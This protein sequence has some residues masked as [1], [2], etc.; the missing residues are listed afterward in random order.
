MRSLRLL[1]LLLLFA[2]V[3]CVAD[4]EELD[5]DAET[6]DGQP[7]PQAAFC[8]LLAR[9]YCEGIQTCGCGDL[10]AC[11]AQL[12]DDCAGPEGFLGPRV[13]AAIAAGEVRYDDAR[14]GVL[15]ERTAM[16][17]PGCDFFSFVAWRVEDLV[18]FGGAISGTRG[19][20]EACGLDWQG[21]SSNDCADSVCDG[22]GSVDAVC[23]AVVEP[24]AA[25]GPEDLCGDLSVTLVAPADASELGDYLS[26]CPASGVCPRREVETPPSVCIE[27]DA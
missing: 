16:G 20:G 6:F 24:E 14:A 26:P 15:L 2:M 22:V 23:R 4:S 11:R 9:A 21:T 18:D 25:C 13:Q 17:S 12:Q 1:P 10:D 19:V 8:L 5:Y 3:G 7:V 27:G